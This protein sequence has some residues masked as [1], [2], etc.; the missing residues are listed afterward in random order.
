M[1]RKLNLL[2][3]VAFISSGTVFSQTAMKSLPAKRTNASFK[4]DGNL[5]EAAWK[6]ALPAQ[7]FV[8]WRPTFG[9]VED[10]SCKTEIYLLYDNTSIYIGGY[11]H[12]KSFDS[13]SRELVGRDQVGVNDYVG[14][15]FDTY[16]DKINGVG[17]YVTPLGEQFDAKYSNS[18]NEDPSWSAVWD[19]EAK[20][21]ADGWTFEMRIPYSA[22]RL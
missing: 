8:E 19:S 16:N 5:D 3:L 7:D 20:L 4:I 2:F 13:V 10:P 21:V 17:F 9:A 22:L 11:C 15:I 18:G 14:I 6:D 12:E 1:K